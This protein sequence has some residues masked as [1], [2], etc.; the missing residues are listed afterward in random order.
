LRQDKEHLLYLWNILGISTVQFN[1]QSSNTT[2]QTRIVRIT[3]VMGNWLEWISINFR[4]WSECIKYRAKQCVNF[5]ENRI[6]E[7]RGNHNCLVN[8]RIKKF[9]EQWLLWYSRVIKGVHNPSTSKPWHLMLPSL[10]WKCSGVLLIDIIVFDFCLVDF[11]CSFDSL[12]YNVKHIAFQNILV[13]CIIHL[14]CS[15]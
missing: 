11:V 12:L 2:Y 13:L 8:T 10:N 9:Y 7:T 14:F 6:I 15:F 1:G 3:F 5:V 4:I